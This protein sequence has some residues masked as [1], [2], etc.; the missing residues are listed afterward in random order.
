MEF[1]QRWT[2][3]L[4]VALFV[5]LLCD[6]DEFLALASWSSWTMVACLRVFLFS[7]FLL[8][9]VVV[10]VGRWSLSNSSSVSHAWSCCV[11]LAFPRQLSSVWFSYVSA[12]VSCRTFH[13]LVSRDSSLMMVL[14]YVCVSTL[15]WPRRLSLVFKSP[16][17]V[18][19]ISFVLLC[20]YVDSHVSRAV[21]YRPLSVLLV[22]GGMYGW[23]TVSWS[24]SST[25]CVVILVLVK[26][27]SSGGVIF[28]VALSVVCQK[29]ALSVCSPA[30]V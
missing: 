20:W 16:I 1:S 9:L 3:V 6:F 19:G 14:R 28:F 30:A 5:E 8:I 21:Q 17:M 25:I 2:S 11:N 12:V 22:S 4:L 7:L 26:S 24:F 15:V 10:R 27:C 29:I 23:T 13:V 18:M